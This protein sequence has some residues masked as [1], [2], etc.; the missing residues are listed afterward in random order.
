MLWKWPSGGGVGRTR[1]PVSTGA[2]PG[3]A[4]PGIPPAA[5]QDAGG[6]GPEAVA[7][8]G[9]AAGA[10]PARWDVPGPVRERA[11]LR[12]SGEREDAHFI[13]NLA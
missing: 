6:V 11:G 10:C 3:A 13:S 12:Q 2:T 9:G 8:E 1:D 5:V 7:G 4:A